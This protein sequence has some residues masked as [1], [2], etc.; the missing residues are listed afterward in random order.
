MNQPGRVASSSVPQVR[1][2]CSSSSIARNPRETQP[3]QLR[4]IRRCSD[5]WPGSAPWLPSRT[6]TSPPMAVLPAASSTVVRSSTKASPPHHPRIRRVSVAPLCSPRRLCIVTLHWLPRL[7]LPLPPWVNCSF[8]FFQ[9]RRD[10]PVSDYQWMESVACCC[11]DLKLVQVR[12]VSSRDRGSK[13][14]PTTP[15]VSK[16]KKTK[17]KFYSYVFIY[18]NRLMLPYFCGNAGRVFLNNGF[19]QSLNL[20]VV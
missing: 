19:N 5:G 18:L 10:L 6:S 15:A 1:R 3:P 12:R 13:R 11:F 7:F 17:M 16:V 2:R 9:S 14:K 20:Q 4:F 8:S